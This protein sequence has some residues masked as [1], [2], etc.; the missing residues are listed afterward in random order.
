VAAWTL[1]M[2]PSLLLSMVLHLTVPCKGA[3]SQ[4]FLLGII[5]HGIRRWFPVQEARGAGFKE[6][7]MGS[8]VSHS[9]SGA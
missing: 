9:N 5:C 1:L 8:T 4:C 3:Q 6:T 2:C 7:N